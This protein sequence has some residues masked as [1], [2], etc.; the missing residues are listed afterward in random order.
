M[1]NTFFVLLSEF[2][3]AVRDCALL[4]YYAMHCYTVHSLAV[5]WLELN[6]PI[7]LIYIQVITLRL[8]DRVK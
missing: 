2:I 4:K 5:N 8:D 6:D 1:L 7:I 3:K